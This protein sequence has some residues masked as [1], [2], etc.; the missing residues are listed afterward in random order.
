MYCNLN[1]VIQIALALKAEDTG[2]GTDDPNEEHARVACKKVLRKVTLEKCEH[3]QCIYGYL[4]EHAPY[5][6]GL[7]KKK[8][9]GKTQ[10][11]MC[12]M[13]QVISQTRSDDASHLHSMISPYAAPHPDKKIVNPPINA[14]GFK[15]RLGFNHLE[16]GRLPCP[17]RNLQGFLEDLSGVRKQLQNG[18]IL[19]TA[20]K[21]PAFLYSGDITGENY[22]PEKSDE[23]FL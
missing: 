7:I 22:D 6:I 3:Y 21:W 4:K 8:R 9:S 20:Q 11:L 10:L 17:V 13:Q 1:K 5:F 15:D 2:S 18:S 16:L 14:R 23:G 19:V 12:E